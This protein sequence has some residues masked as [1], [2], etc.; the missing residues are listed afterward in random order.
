MCIR[1]RGKY[2]RAYLDRMR[3]AYDD[4]SLTLD[5]LRQHWQ[6]AWRRHDLDLKRYF[7]GRSNFFAFDI[8]VPAE[9]AALCRFLRR[10][11]YRIRGKVLPHAGA[12]SSPAAS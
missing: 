1:D 6:E 9:Q 10:R 4:L 8:S 11:G 3:R 5:D 12:R 7:A 2:A